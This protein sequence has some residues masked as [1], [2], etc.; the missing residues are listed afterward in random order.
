V[1]EIALN[2]SDVSDPYH[3]IEL[4]NGQLVVSHVEPVHGVSVVNSRGQVVASS[5]SNLQSAN[6]PFNSPCHLAVCENGRI[7]V[8][9]E[10]N[11]RIVELNDSLTW[12]RDLPLTV[13]GGLQG[14]RCLYLDKSHDRL[15]VGEYCGKRV[16]V[17]ENLS[18]IFISS[19]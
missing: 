11:N 18:N 8:A 14:P 17:F 3:A 15:F 7:L 9:D 16:L 19:D 10:G 1:R 6:K 2:E 5:R 12:S 4:T 13:S